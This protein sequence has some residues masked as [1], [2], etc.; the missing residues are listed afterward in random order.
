MLLR[1]RRV[2][3]NRGKMRRRLGRRSYKRELTKRSSGRMSRIHIRR[4]GMTPRGRGFKFRK[5]TRR[6][7]RIGMRKIGG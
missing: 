1:K 6:K 7:R 4:T 5:P 3:T 2:R